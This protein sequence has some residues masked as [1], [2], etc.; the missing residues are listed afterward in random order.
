MSRVITAR[1]AE[2]APDT[3]AVQRRTLRV[4]FA[5]QVISGVGFAIG[6][7]V[8]AL[9]AAEMAGVGMSGIA[10]SAV[11]VGGALFAIPATA[12]VRHR[13]R[14]LSLAGGYAVA[15]VGALVIVLAAMSNAVPLLFAGFLL[16]GGATAAGFQARYAA[17]D[18]APPALRARH[19]S[20]VVWATTIGAVAGPNLAAVAGAALDPHGVPTLA[21][22]FFFSALLLG[23]AA[24]VL[25]LLMRPDPIIVAREAERALARPTGSADAGDSSRLAGDRPADGMRAALR[26][27]AGLPVARSGLTAMTVGHAVMIAVMAMT[28]VHIRGAGHDATVTLRIVGI[29][30]SMHIAG[31]FAFAPVMGWLADRFGRRSVILGGIALLLLACALA[32]TAGHQTGRLAGA[33]MVLGLGWSATMVAGSTLFSE[34]VPASLRAS[35]QGLSDL[36]IGLAGACAGAL[37]GVVLHVGSY[38]LLAAGAALL[39]ATLILPALAVTPDRGYAQGA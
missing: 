37:S 16:F 20:I 30:L 5:T 15:T 17:L 3:A 11:V 27:V 1:I 13:G 12:I 8:G 32:A 22:P 28:P 14:R 21:A 9:L 2:S 26:A 36:V 31:M 24:I 35:G 19:L 6:A 7:S 25:L 4:L 33:M 34:A 18:L 38:A 10:Q 23:L 29:V 39:A